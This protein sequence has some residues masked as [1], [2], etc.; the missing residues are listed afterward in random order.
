MKNGTFLT[1]A[2]L[3]TILSILGSMGGYSDGME[4][5]TFAPFCFALMCLVQY[6]PAPTTAKVRVDPVNT[7][8]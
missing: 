5:L 6:L 7:S 1:I 2:L 4:G 8:I 3:A